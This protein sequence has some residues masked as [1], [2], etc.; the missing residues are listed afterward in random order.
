MSQHEFPSLLSS[1][2]RSKSALDFLVSKYQECRDQH[3]GCKLQA[4]STEIYPSRLID[5]GESEDTLV[6]LREMQ[7]WSNRDMYICLSHCWGQKQPLMLTKE[8][9][10]ILQDG[11]QVSTLP[12]TFQDA[13][14]VTR[15]LGVRF[16][17][18]DSLYVS[19]A[20]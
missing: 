13:I 10:P 8:S 6:F 17:W 4:G 3:A 12:R 9:K 14:F 16:L 15:L 19:Y 1:N 11:M 20:T 7:N 5:V 18:I 2:T